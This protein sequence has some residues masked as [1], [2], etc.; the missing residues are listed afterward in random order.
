MDAV[1]IGMRT[2]LRPCK[3]TV[4]KSYFANAGIH[5]AADGS[6][7]KAC[8]GKTPAFGLDQIASNDVY[9]INMSPKDNTVNIK[10]EASASKAPAAGKSY[11]HGDLRDALIAAGMRLLERRSSEDLGLREVAR[12]VGVSATAVYRHFP[13]KNALLRAI[14]AR[15]FTLMGD[16]QTA[17][18]AGAKDAAAFAAVGGAY[19]R[20]ALRNPAVFRLMFSSAPPKDLFSMPLEDLSSPMRQLRDYV[21]ALTPASLSEEERKIISIRA[22]A[23]VHGLALLALDHVIEMDDA[24]I[25]RVIGGHVRDMGL[26][27]SPAS[28]PASPVK[29]R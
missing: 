29:K 2:I 10:S 21:S 3:G 6:L 5:R 12:E 1:E 22:W 17:A 14:A 7:Y 24:L 26:D 13:D 18:V 28:H 23:L 27:R 19:V 25:D 16:M 11:H 15:G 9:T 20:F 4:Q 8:H